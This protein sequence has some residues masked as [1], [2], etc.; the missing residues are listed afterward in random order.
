[1][2]FKFN[3]VY[4]IFFWTLNVNSVMSS[5]LGQ[6][7]FNGRESHSNRVRK[8][9]RLCT[10]TWHTYRTCPCCDQGCKCM[11]LD[12]PRWTDWRKRLSFFNHCSPSNGLI[13]PTSEEANKMVLRF[14]CLTEPSFEGWTELERIKISLKS[15]FV[16]LLLNF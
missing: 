1:M 8:L 2:N 4:Y 16:G 10:A 5:D 7:L 14:S 9:S 15:P 12:Q 11:D 13:A 6:E 3:M